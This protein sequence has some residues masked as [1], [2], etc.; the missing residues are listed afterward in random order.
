MLSKSP[1]SSDL[2]DIRLECYPTALD[3]FSHFYLQQL[4]RPLVVFF[5]KEQ[6]ISTLYLLF[7]IQTTITRPI[8]ELLLN[9]HLGLVQPMFPGIG[10]EL[11][12][13]FFSQT[14][15]VFLDTPNVLVRPRMLLR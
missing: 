13:F 5:Y 3:M 8:P 9:R 1:R 10:R 11:R 4:A 12:C 14:L 7:S 15:T 2:Y 6:S